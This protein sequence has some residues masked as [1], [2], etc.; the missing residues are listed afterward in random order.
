MKWIYLIAAA[1]LTLVF[2]LPFHEYDT[3]RLLPLLTVQAAR[4]DSGVTIVSE[5]GKGEGATW[6]AAVEDLRK[7]ASGEVFFDT[8]EQ[9]IFCDR[10]LIPD[11]LKSNVLRP[12]AQV[13]F[14]DALQDPEGLHEYLSA[15]E[16]QI[17]VA[18]LRA[19]STECV[20]TCSLR[21][22]RPVCAPVSQ[23]TREKR[24]CLCR[25]GTCPR[26]PRSG[27]QYRR[28]GLCA[29]GSSCTGAPSR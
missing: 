2:G 13:Y 27:R 26:R 29:F 23:S 11:A 25:A 6:E 9:V 22:P 5:T 7:N 1:V 10:T 3:A 8:A 17:T 28:T 15:H 16:S 20:Q 14:A 12:A 18:D 19:G 21:L 24:N 4:T